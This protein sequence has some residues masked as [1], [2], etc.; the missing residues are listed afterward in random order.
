MQE[1]LYPELF[2]SLGSLSNLKS[3][4]TENVKIQALYWIPCQPLLLNQSK[5]MA[6]SMRMV[7]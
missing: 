1:Y 7:F 6:H 5:E 4:E 2:N 3:V